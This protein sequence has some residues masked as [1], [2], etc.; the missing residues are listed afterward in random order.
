MNKHLLIISLIIAAAFLPPVS[1]IAQQEELLTTPSAGA[2]TTSPMP[3]FAKV[4]G[5]VI[6]TKTV[7]VRGGPMRHLVA[8]V[9]S[10]RGNLVYVDLGPAQRAEELALRHGQDVTLYGRLGRVED[11]AVLLADRVQA[12]DRIMVLRGGQHA[13]AAAG[14][15]AALPP[16]DYRQ[17]R[18]RGN[19]IRLRDATTRAGDTNQIAVLDTRRGRLYV[20]LGSK[21]DLSGIDFQPGQQLEVRGRLARVGDRPI[22]IAREFQMGGDVTRRIAR[23]QQQARR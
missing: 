6:D 2:A 16:G 4:T 9:Q 21:K 7:S 8:R 12:N 5:A 23:E 10:D 17:I 11:S 19:L 22:L 14:D 18:A 13:A 1:A 15:I 20:D 3:R